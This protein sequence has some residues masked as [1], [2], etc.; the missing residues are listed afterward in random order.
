MRGRNAHHHMHGDTGN[1]PMHPRRLM[2]AVLAGA[3][4]FA[5]VSAARA[6]GVPVLD[7]ASFW[8][9]HYTLRLPVY[10]KD[11]QL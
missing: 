5:S 11:G 9:M 8:R 4:L 6:E 1:G 7:T 2:T 10:L 3:A